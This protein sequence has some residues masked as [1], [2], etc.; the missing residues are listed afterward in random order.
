MVTWGVASFTDLGVAPVSDFAHIHEELPNRDVYVS[1]PGHLVT[2]YCMHIL[3]HLAAP[4]CSS[5]LVGTSSL[6]TLS[7]FVSRQYWHWTHILNKLK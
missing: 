2:I 5:P 4:V 1:I 3:F 6:A 7:M